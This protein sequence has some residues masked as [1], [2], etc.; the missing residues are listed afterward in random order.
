[1]CL[2]CVENFFMN[3][4]VKICP[5]VICVNLDYFFWGPGQKSTSSVELCSLKSENCQFLSSVPLVGVFSI[6]L[7]VSHLFVF[8]LYRLQS[9][10]FFTLY[11][12]S[13]CVL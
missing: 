1:M 9:L 8:F 7:T 12:L 2:K 5:F 10:L 13:E 11:G 3:V 6:S 4:C